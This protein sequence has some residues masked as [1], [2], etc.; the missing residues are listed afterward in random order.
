MVAGEDIDY[1]LTVTNTGNVALTGVVVTDTNAPDC[2]TTIGALAVGAAAAVI[3]CS[4]TTVAGDVGTRTNTATVDSAQT[5]PVNSN[6]VSTTV[7]AVAGAWPVDLQ[8]QGSG[9]GGGG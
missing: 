9:V 8:D 4:Y 2:A 3:D 6:Q 1:H 5:S 7:T